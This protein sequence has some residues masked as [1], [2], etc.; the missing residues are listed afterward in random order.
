MTT[1]EPAT[2]PAP[3]DAPSSAPEGGHTRERTPWLLCVLCFLVPALPTYV[4][5][6]GALKGNGAPARMIALIMF[7]LVVLGFMLV[8]RTSQPRRVNPGALIILLYFALWLMTY[9]VGL[10][11]NDDYVTASNKSRALVGLIAHVGVGLYVIARIRTARQQNIVLGCLAVGLTFA[12]LVGLLQA[13]ASLDLRLLL[14]PPGFVLN[15]EINITQLS[16]ERQGVNRVTS[17]SQHPIE[18]SVL[19]AVTIPLTIYFA[20]NAAIRRVRLLSGAACVVAML[21]LPAAVSRS[22]IFS[23][24]T[25]LLVYMFAFK[26]RPIAIAVSAIFLAT[27]GYM[28][29]FPQIANAL[30]ST[31]TGSAEDASVESRV[32]D[33]A[34]VS[35]SF[36]EHPI[37][38]LGL[39][40]SVPTEFGYLD[41]EWM[42]A[43]VQGG[44]VGLT[45]MALISGGAI[46]GITAALRTATSQ[47]EREQAY[48]LGAMAVGILASSFTFDLFGFEQTAVIYFIVLGLLWSR[49]NI[50]IPEP[51][52]HPPD[53]IGSAS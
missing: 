24:V 9:G 18:F 42:G 45:A 50:P 5:L 46:F 47:R 25:A 27:A 49:F 8:R 28:I 2:A 14:Q 36:R 11:N 23:Q 34:R 40:G 1:T 39:G 21:A 38:G 31:I 19:A 44:V 29:V 3:A 30:W 37:F 17:T 10:L 26:I 16:F 22:G 48:M 6:P 41:N 43:I 4:V 53:R 15:S 20:R 51:N 13:V 52:A 35:A 33:Y 12:C 7:G 32:E